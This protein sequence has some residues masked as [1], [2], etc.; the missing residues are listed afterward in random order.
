MILS[1]IIPAYNA[2]RYL[3]EAILSVLRQSGNRV[4]ILV[5]DDGS[6]DET[7]QIAGAYARRYSNVRL[8]RTENMGVAHARNVGIKAASG[9]YIAF[10]DADDVLCADAYSTQTEQ[11]LASCG[12]DMISFGYL[13]S[14]HT[15]KYGSLIPETSGSM[16]S[17][18]PDFVRSA[19][20]KSF[21]S[22]L[23]RRGLL[24]NI[25]FFEGIRYSE[26]SVFLYR[27]ARQAKN[28]LQLDLYWFVYRNNIHSALHRTN[29]WRFILTDHV[30]AWHQA[31]A[32][33][34]SAAVQWDCFG[35]AYAQMAQ[36]L[37][38]GAM[39]GVPLKQL[40]TD[41]RDSKAFQSIA[42]REGSFWVKTETT[43]I[44][45][46]FANN[47]RITW[48]KYRFCGLFSETARTLSRAPLLRCLYLRMK[49][50]CKLAPWLLPPL[51]EPPAIPSIDIEA[52][53]SAL[54]KIIS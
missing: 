33:S 53:P 35:M 15:L 47:P 48:L 23:Y 6:T 54:V 28:L 1:V 7:P 49:Y 34:D 38:L 21:C 31:G 30:T 11:L 44:L 5:V 45:Q 16:R 29:G 8:I 13:H 42:A 46:S 27:A 18:Q 51:P 17:S 2:Q 40:Q 20:R 39:S 10:L 22:Y 37:R 52:H 24:K 50:R 26:D 14:D 36:Y 43:K 19:S 4:E 12:Y 32:M 41:L 25:R 3:E 9:V